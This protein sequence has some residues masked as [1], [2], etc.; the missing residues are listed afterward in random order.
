MKLTLGNLIDNSRVPKALGL[1]PRTNVEQRTRFLQI[2]NEGQQR[3]IPQGL[4]VGTYGRFRMCVTDGCVSLAPQLASIE[5]V[6]LYG[7]VI[8]SHDMLYEFLDNG[9][10][11][12][13]A[14]STTGTGTCGGGGSC[15]M[16][17]ANLRG[18]FPSFGD[19]RGSAKKLRFACD[20]SSDVDKTVLALGYD[21]N[22]N[23]IRTTQGSV[24][25]DG[26]LITLAQAPGTDST[27]F[28]SSLTGVQFPDERDGQ[29]WLWER[30]T[31]A[32]TSR[33]IGNYQYWETD[34]DYPRYFFPS[35]LAQQ[36]SNG[37]TATTIELIGKLDFVPVKQDTDYLIIRNVPALKEMCVG[38][39]KAEDEADSSVSNDIII[40]AEALAIHYLDQEL[41]HYNGQGREVGMNVR[42]PNIGSNNPVEALL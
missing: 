21:D 42:G 14:L 26:E 28:F 12:R 33:L 37:C 16:A 2:V 17:E 27:K 39:K 35:V 11:P 1:C 30:D 38:I 29:V 8:P 10:G 13:N 6:A 24:V 3:L 40:K 4:Y 34:P 41:E 5:R 23:W 36:T 20:L 31:V 19:I 7:R 9:F 15:G 32:S 25:A 22:G 18:Y